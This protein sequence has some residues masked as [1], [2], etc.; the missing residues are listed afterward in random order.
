MTE[1]KKMEVLEKVKTHGVRFVRLQFTDV[2][3][4]LK[5]VAIPASQVEKALEGDLMFDGSS[6]EGFARIEESDMYLIPDPDTF[7]IMPWRPSSGAV[8]RMICDVYT[9]AKEPFIGDPAVILRE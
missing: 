5:N 3:G 2:N 7:A 9:P 8:A 1:A 4:V 6:I